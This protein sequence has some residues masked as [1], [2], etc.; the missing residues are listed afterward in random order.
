M[1]VARKLAKHLFCLFAIFLLCILQMVAYGAKQKESLS[2][3]HKEM[4]EQSLM[5]IDNGYVEA[6]LFMAKELQKSSQQSDVHSHWE[7][8]AITI[9]QEAFQKSENYDSS[10][11]YCYAGME[12]AE[13]RQDNFELA[14]FKNECG[15][16]YL[17]ASKP[18]LAIEL[19][20]ESVEAFKLMDSTDYVNYALGN[21]AIAYGM[22]DSL[23]K[24]EDILREISSMDK[25]SS[26]IS[27][28]QIATHINL[29][30]V[31]IQQKHFQE[32]LHVIEKIEHFKDNERYADRIALIKGQAYATLDVDSATFYLE[33]AL[34]HASIQGNMPLYEIISL[35]FAELNYQLKRYEEASAH[36]KRHIFTRD[37]IKKVLDKQ[38]IESLGALYKI[39]Q[40]V[41]AI[42]Q[43]V[44]CKFV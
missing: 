32:A 9:I 20:Q 2:K 34:N 31:Y 15:K 30:V 21:L 40:K 12:L 18:N 3:E 44:Q 22:I 36:Y 11:Y 29:A 28:N 25:Q 43:T 19:I 23:N 6:A 8:K 35:E 24:C 26:Y 16:N 33:K 39:N 14:R 7:L 42:K 37:S 17:L 27:H 5:Y 41:R 4:Y 13:L 38:Y 1:K 10:L